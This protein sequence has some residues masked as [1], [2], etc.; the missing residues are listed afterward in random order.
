MLRKTKIRVAVIV[1]A[2][3]VVLLGVTFGAAEYTTR[4]SFCNSCHEMNPYYHGWQVSTHNVAECKDCHI[5]K[6]FASFV[7]TK[8]FAMREVYVHFAGGNAVPLSVRRQVSNSV[9]EQCHRDGGTAKAIGT[10]SLASSTFAHTGR[11]VGSC[12]Q[13]GCHQRIVHQSVSPPT[14]VWPASMNACFVCHEGSTASKKCDYCHKNAPH[15]NSG[16]CDSCHSLTTWKLTDFKHPFALEGIH[17]T[18]A[19]TKCH[20]AAAPGQGIKVPGSTAVFNFGKAPETCIVCHGDKHNG[21]KECA[22]CHTAQR[23]TPAN[24]SHPRVGPHVGGGR[25]ERSITDCAVCHDQGFASASCSCH[26]GQRFTAGQ[27]LPQGGD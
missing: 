12:V 2:A 19:C 6:G 17:A 7:K 21:L 5:P 11:H 18:L 27:P 26:G 13:A 25:A 14:Y 20:P 8:V 1:V 23:W 3:V 10:V 24:F 16:Q 4:S 15:N 22:Q 9:C